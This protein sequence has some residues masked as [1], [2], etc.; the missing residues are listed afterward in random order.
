[1]ENYKDEMGE[2]PFREC[3]GLEGA[4]ISEEHQVDL[5]LEA[6]RHTRETCLKLIVQDITR[7][8]GLLDGKVSDFRHLGF[9]YETSEASHCLR[10]GETVC[11]VKTQLENDPYFPSALKASQSASR[12]RVR[13]CYR[14]RKRPC[15][16]SI[17]SRYALYRIESYPPIGSLGGRC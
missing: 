9:A 1:M 4:A 6:S 15:S 2:H 10:H 8:S 14:H 3:R 7:F 5:K 13:F 11:I 17:A 16:T 12:G